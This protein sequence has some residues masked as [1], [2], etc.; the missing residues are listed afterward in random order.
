VMCLP[1]Q[2]CSEHEEKYSHM[3]ECLSK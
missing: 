2:H 1:V 3:Y